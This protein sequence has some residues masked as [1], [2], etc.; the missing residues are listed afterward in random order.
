MSDLKYD[1]QQDDG[2]VFCLHQI[3][4]GIVEKNLSI[5]DLGHIRPDAQLVGEGLPGPHVAPLELGGQ[6]PDPIARLQDRCINGHGGGPAVGGFHGLG[7]GAPTPPR[8]AQGRKG[9]V[10]RRRV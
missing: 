3:P 1:P 10:H 5:H 9:P 4:A 8:P 6:A 2:P 7:P